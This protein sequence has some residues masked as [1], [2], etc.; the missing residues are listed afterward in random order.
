MNTFKKFIRYIIIGILLFLFVTFASTQF[1]KQT[2]HE[3]KSSVETSSPEIMIQEAKATNVN[4]Y[5]K[6]IINNN[7][8]SDMNEIYLKADLYGITGTYLGTKQLD[9]GSFKQD[10]AKEFYIN[11][12]SSEVEEVKLSLTN[13][14]KKQ[15]TFSE[16][17]KSTALKYLGLTILVMAIIK[18]IL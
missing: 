13:E 3:I 1:V 5:A 9:L 15:E 18:G 17:D 12:K 4:G 7:T 14:G 8:S 2:Y 16:T 11:F 10:E 6:G